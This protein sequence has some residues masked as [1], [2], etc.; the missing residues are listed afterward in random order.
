MWKKVILW[1]FSLID[2]SFQ[3]CDEAKLPAFLLIV[4]Q[5]RPV[6]CQRPAAELADKNR[7][8][9]LIRHA[10]HMLKYVCLAYLLIDSEQGFPRSAQGNH[11]LAGFSSRAPQRI[12]IVTVDGVR[13]PLSAAILF[14]RRSRRKDRPLC[15]WR[16][17]GRRG[18]KADGSHLLIHPQA[19]SWLRDD[20]SWR[21]FQQF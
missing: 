6:L 19:A 20:F 11:Y 14:D 3:I 9:V 2:C 15:G 13:Q 21:S 18:I 17:S 4:F 16:V 8:I 7:L 12:M 10:V 5:R 1:V